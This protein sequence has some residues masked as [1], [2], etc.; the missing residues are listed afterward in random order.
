MKKEQPL[1]I[2]N[3]MTT[4]Y[5]QIMAMSPLKL[6]EWLAGNFKIDIPQEILTPEDMENASRVLLKLS[7]WYAYLNTLLA[8]AKTMK[9]EAKRKGDKEA[10]EDMV[11]RQEVL[12]H[13]N[14][15]I[16]QSYSAI[17]RAVT[18]RIEVGQELR[19]GGEMPYSNRGLDQ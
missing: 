7:S 18:I 6:A 4:R 16:K 13:I 2:P 5:A 9:R 14:D 1:D 10:F 15:I 8:L 17:S 19:L 12:Q 11:D 3:G